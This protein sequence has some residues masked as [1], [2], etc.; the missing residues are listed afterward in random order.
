MV[1]LHNV[2]WW[3]GEADRLGLGL[4]R[5]HG[6]GGNLQGTASETVEKFFV[7]GSDHVTMSICQ[8]TSA[9]W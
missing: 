1:R 4:V 7:A 5:Q 9:V 6:G 8:A 3:K 2:I